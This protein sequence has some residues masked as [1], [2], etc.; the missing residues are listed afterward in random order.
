MNTHTVTGNLITGLFFAAGIFSFV[1]GQFILSTTLL[2]MA[3]LIANI[4]SAKPARI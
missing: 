4:Y 3:S 1:S 2:G